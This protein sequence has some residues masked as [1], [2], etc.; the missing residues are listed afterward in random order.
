MLVNIILLLL[1][2]FVDFLVGCCF[3][4]G[5][6]KKK[7]TETTYPFS[8]A[9]TVVEAKGLKRSDVFT[10]DPFALVRLGGSSHKTAVRKGSR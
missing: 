7:G 5:G 10:V 2:C 8:V 3:E 9:V 1:V 4:A 6:V